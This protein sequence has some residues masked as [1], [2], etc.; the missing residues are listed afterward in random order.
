VNKPAVGQKV[1][2]TTCGNLA[3]KEVRELFGEVSR[4]GR[5]YFNVKFD[6]SFLEINCHIDGWHQNNGEYIADYEV[7]ESKEEYERSKQM[8]D[9]DKK[10]A[11]YFSSFGRATLTLDQL[12]KVA[13]IIGLENAPS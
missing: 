6:G 8:A 10:I 3:R 5:K 4:V 9:L 13:E 7:W 1:F 12:E 2:I 11:K